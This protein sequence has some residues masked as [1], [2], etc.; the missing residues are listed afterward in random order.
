MRSAAPAF[1]VG[2]AGRGVERLEC[3]PSAP[4]GGGSPLAA[5]LGRS[6]P[7]TCAGATRLLSPQE[8]GQLQLL[9][10]LRRNAPAQKCWRACS[11]PG[12]LGTALPGLST[13]LAQGT[14]RGCA[15]GR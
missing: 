6:R 4:C 10:P 12:N 9:G 5:G 14:A 8:G 13:M 1:A 7:R 15:L 11:R 3:L 2:A